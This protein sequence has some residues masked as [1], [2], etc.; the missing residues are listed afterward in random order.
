MK[1]IK[2]TLNGN[3]RVC[4]QKWKWYFIW[5]CCGQRS[6]SMSVI[7][8]TFLC[9]K[10]VCFSKINIFKNKSGIASALDW[11]WSMH[12]L[13]YLQLHSFPLFAHILRSVA[14]FAWWHLVL[15]SLHNSNSSLL[16]DYNS[17]RCLKWNKNAWFFMMESEK[18]W[19]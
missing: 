6:R 17:F 3:V 11:F 19:D 16:W 7:S 4:K 10:S 1:G 14:F 18:E 2:Q 15:L 13:V 5:I 12:L 8:S 9:A